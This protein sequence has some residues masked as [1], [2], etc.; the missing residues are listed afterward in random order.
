VTFVFAPKYGLLVSRQKA[1][2]ALSE[3]SLE[4][5]GGQESAS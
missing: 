5:A 4:Q 3:Q 1:K 2:E